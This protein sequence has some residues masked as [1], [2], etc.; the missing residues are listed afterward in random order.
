MR[1]ALVN[2]NSDLCAIDNR[3]VM[4]ITGQDDDGKKQ[5]ENFIDNNSKY[6]TIVTTAELL[7]TGVDCKMCKVIALDCPSQAKL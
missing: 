2:E 1:Q 3:Y 6:P 4:R 5:L 7:S